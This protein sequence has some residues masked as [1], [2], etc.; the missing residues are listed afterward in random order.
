MLFP[1]LLSLYHVDN[2][3]IRAF[4]QYPLTGEFLRVSFNLRL[5]YAKNGLVAAVTWR[6]RVSEAHKYPVSQLRVCVNILGS[7]YR[8]DRTWKYRG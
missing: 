4:S 7:T 5:Q 3:P 1:F 6:S 8:P 2:I